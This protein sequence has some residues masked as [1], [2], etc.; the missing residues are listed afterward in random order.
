[1]QHDPRAPGGQEF[2]ELLSLLGRLNYVW[3]N[4]ESVLI[5]VIAGLARTD[6][7][8]ATLVF[9]TLNTTRARINLVERLVK[10]E[11]ESDSLRKEILALTKRLSQALAL[12]NK[13][14]H[15]IYSFNADD[16]SAQAILMR[17]QDRAT[18]IQYGKSQAVNA[19]TIAKTEQVLDDLRDINDHLWAI[20]L[21]QS[22]PI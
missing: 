12:R 17:I 1:M 16:G 19:G 2:E 9:L 4:T 22:Y 3:T 15:C 11:R 7:D 20:I 6:I 21:K 10:L 14:N 18:Q 8:T 13:F 5:H